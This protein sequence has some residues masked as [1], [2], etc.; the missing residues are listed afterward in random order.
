MSDSMPFFYW[1]T[2]LLKGYRGVLFLCFCDSL[3]INKSSLHYKVIG[4]KKPR[5]LASP[6]SQHKQIMAE[7]DKT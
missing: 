1:K 4:L 7:A 3:I 2:V 5:A 6:I